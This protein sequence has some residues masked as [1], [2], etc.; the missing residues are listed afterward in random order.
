VRKQIIVEEQ[1]LHFAVTI[2]DGAALSSD[3]NKL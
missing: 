3:S 2:V 1:R